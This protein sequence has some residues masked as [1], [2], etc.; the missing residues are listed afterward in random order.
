M[1]RLVETRDTGNGVMGRGV[2]SLLLVVI[3]LAVSLSQ[4][5]PKVNLEEFL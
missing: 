4:A 3:T 1:T 5:L 2:G